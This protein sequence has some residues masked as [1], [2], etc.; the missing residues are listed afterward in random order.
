MLS[1]AYWLI[2]QSMKPQPFLEFP[3]TYQW[4][5]E[6][7]DRIVDITKDD[8][9]IIFVGVQDRIYSV[10]SK[11]GNTLWQSD[12]FVGLQYQMLSSQ[13]A[14]YVLGNSKLWALKKSN[15]S[16]SWVTEINQKN[17]RLVT[18]SKEYVVLNKLSDDIRVYSAEDGR[19]LWYQ[20]TSRGW[21][22]AYINNETV[23]VLDIGIRASNLI[24]GETIW[25]VGNSIIAGSFYD[26]NSDIIYYA[27]DGKLSAFDVLSK[28]EKWVLNL[29][30]K[31]TPSISGSDEI[32]L[33]ADGINNVYCIDTITGFLQWKQRTNSP[34]NPVVGK[35]NIF[36]VNDFP[37]TITAFDWISGDVEGSL[38]FG[39]PKLLSIN[40]KKVIYSNDFLIFSIGRT[41]YAYGY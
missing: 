41:L 23:F 17:L 38:R 16:I 11:T 35:E 31:G 27:S 5:K 20:A 26:N 29:E 3:L 33:V 8:S 10:D 39:L 14:L 28:S 6:F 30:Y 21:I 7:Q 25:L 36:I 34:I 22:D 15:G 24:N 9:D 1:L 2:D 19:M 4:S 37:K 18:A 13:N 12:L 32:L 40:P